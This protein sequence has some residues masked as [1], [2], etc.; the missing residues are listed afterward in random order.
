MLS[1]QSI[2]QILSFHPSNGIYKAFVLQGGVVNCVVS[3]LLYVR[4][5][6]RVNTPKLSRCSFI[7]GPSYSLTLHHNYSV[8]L[9][10]EK[11]HC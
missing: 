2:G 4:P 6:Q 10:S 8:G 3:L 1:A 5:G 11:A 7:N 9:D